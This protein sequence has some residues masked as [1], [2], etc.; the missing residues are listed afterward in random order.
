MSSAHQAVK[1]SFKVAYELLKAVEKASDIF[2]LLKAA[3]SAMLV[4]VDHIRVSLW[5]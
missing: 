1:I 2:L 3:M 5:F 4:I